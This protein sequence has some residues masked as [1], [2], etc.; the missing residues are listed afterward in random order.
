MTHTNTISDEVFP[1]YL[2]S[3]INLILY[4]TIKGANT[5]TNCNECYVDN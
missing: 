5:R 3:G 1:L 4:H 2:E